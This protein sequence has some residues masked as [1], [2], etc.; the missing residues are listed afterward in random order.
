MSKHSPLDGIKQQGTWP[1]KCPQRAFVEGASWWQFHANGAAAFSSERHEMENEAVRR[2]G[3][4]EPLDTSSA[5]TTESVELNRLLNI[6]FDLGAG[7]TG[8]DIG[9]EL[10]E[11]LEV[12]TPKM[13]PRSGRLAIRRRLGRYRR[14]RK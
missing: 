11:A 14:V 3:D 8:H 9:M 12:V 5:F 6:V 13:K 2:F 1:E 4:P 7:A 10:L